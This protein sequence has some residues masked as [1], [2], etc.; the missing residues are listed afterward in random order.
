MINTT[1]F[2]KQMTILFD[3]VKQSFHQFQWATEVNYI[4][5]LA[6]PNYL[7]SFNSWHFIT[8]VA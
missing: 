1:A 2:W 8:S 5:L 6:Y 4:S 7:A 3:K